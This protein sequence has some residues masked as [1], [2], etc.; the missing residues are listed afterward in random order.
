MEVNHNKIA[1]TARVV[2]ERNSKGVKVRL[3]YTY[4]VSY[5]HLTVTGY[6]EA[7]VCFEREAVNGKIKKSEWKEALEIANEIACR[8]RIPLDI[9]RREPEEC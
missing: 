2:L 5:T 4:S 3:H 1:R 9:D 8:Y 6:G 7:V